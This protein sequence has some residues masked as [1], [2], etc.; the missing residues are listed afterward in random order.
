MNY[1]QLAVATVVLALAL[2]FYTKYVIVPGL[3]R[4]T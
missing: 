2:T 4:M 3:K 1:A